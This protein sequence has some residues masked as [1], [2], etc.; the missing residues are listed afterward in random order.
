MLRVSLI[1]PGDIEFHYHNLLGISQDKFYSI[2][3]KLAKSLSKSDVELELLPDRGVSLE[4]AKKFKENKG[5]R[6]VASIPKSDTG[7]GIA[8]LTPYINT[9]VRGKKLFDEEIDTGD[10]GQQN[11][12]KGLL[13]DV[14]LF[15]GITFATELEMNYALYLTRLMKGTK[16]GV[17][18]AQYLHPEVRAGKNIPYTFLIYSPFLKARK[19]P[20]ETEAYMKKY[21]INFEYIKNSRQLRQKLS[22]LN[23]LL[24]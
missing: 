10:W 3:E 8:H 15:L 21:G 11:R 22:E 14:T 9:E 12:L 19:L 2:L 16:K 6:V 17:E 13:G 5:G 7:Y 4:L 18:N 20:F 1:G 23:S 24:G